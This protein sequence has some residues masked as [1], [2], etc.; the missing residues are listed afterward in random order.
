MSSGILEIEKNDFQSCFITT[1]ISSLKFYNH[2]VQLSYKSEALLYSC[3]SME[4][5]PNIAKVDKYFIIVDLSDKYIKDIIFNL[6]DYILPLGP[7]ICVKIVKN[8]KLDNEDISNCMKLLNRLSKHNI[9]N[10]EVGHSPIEN[11]TTPKVTLINKLK[12]LFNS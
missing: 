3:M 10:V 12:G 9:I 4:N 1:G 8:N 6:F 7:E 2:C 5:I 11:V